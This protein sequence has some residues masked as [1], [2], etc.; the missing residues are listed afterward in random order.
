MTLKGRRRP[1]FSRIVTSE[2]TASGPVYIIGTVPTPKLDIIPSDEAVPDDAHSAT[3]D[4]S[5]FTYLVG[6]KFRL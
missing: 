5:G 4:F 2:S 1:L 6:L 3:L